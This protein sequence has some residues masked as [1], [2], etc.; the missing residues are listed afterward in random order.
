M[1]N[2]EPRGEYNSKSDYA[3]FSV[4]GKL[5]KGKILD[6]GCGS[7]ELKKYLP[8]DCNYTGIDMDPSDKWLITG[9]VYD[10]PF[11]D[12]LFD[13]VAILEVLEHLE[14]PM[15]ALREIKRVVKD[16][17]NVIISV[18]NPYNLDQIASI[19]HNDINIEN[20]NHI[21]IFGDNEIRSM[22]FHAGFSLV[23]PVRFYTKIPGLNWLSPIRSRF[24]EWSIYEV[25]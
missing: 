14:T 9:S 3:R 6:A 24:G 10:L 19:L 13:T 15:N 16:G 5:C 17:G 4:I 21:N 7:G 2:Q 8:K 1:V 22:C 12:N 23:H 25:R 11:E 20:I 18:P